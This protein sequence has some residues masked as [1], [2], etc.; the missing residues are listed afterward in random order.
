[1]EDM[2]DRIDVVDRMVNL[3]AVKMA[4]AGKFISK[5]PAERL[6]QQR[7]LQRRTSGA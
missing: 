4:Y 1:M 7:F 6:V 5:R 3:N 2:I